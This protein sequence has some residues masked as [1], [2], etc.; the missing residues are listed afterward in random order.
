M[1]LDLFGHDARGQNVGALR[2]SVG[3]APVLSICV[4]TVLGH[5][6]TVVPA[7]R[8]DLVALRRAQQRATPCDMTMTLSARPG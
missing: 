8:L 2:I 3:R 5:Y 1:A 7:Q 4:S 6:K